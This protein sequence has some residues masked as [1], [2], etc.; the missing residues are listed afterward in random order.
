M[1]S[2]LS[3][4]TDWEKRNPF[5]LALFF[6]GWD[7]SVCLQAQVK[8]IYLSGWSFRDRKL[9]LCDSALLFLEADAHILICSSMF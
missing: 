5:P 4:A 3:S 9:G 2:S 7:I 1:V 6:M 8:L